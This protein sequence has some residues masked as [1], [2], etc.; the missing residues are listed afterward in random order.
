MLSVVA[1][2]GC[3]VP[4][5]LEFSKFCPKNMMYRIS[6]NSFLPWIVS[7][8][9]SFR[10]NYSIHEVKN[11]HNA[12]IIWKFSYFPLSK[13]K[14]VR[15]NYSQKYGNSESWYVKR[16]QCVPVC[17]IVFTWHHAGIASKEL[18]FSQPYYL[19][20]NWLQSSI[21]RG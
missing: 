10:A 20:K 15:R 18:N 4:L 9:N 14:S 16:V 12:E 6:A 3:S 2:P 19:G 7:P 8:F 5:W 1:R 17:C 13:K 11:C 21:F